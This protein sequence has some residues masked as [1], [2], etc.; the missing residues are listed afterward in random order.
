MHRLRAAPGG[1]GRARM[2]A[3]RAAR[4]RAR[5]AE[6]NATAR[7]GAGAP[8][9]VLE[10]AFDADIQRL[11]K[12]EGMWDKP[13]ARK[14]APLPAAV[15]S[16]AAAAIKAA[17]S[18]GGTAAAALGYKDLHAARC[19]WNTAHAPPGGRR[20]QAW[21]MPAG[22][23]LTAPTCGDAATAAAAAAASAAPALARPAARQCSPHLPL[24]SAAAVAAA[25]AHAPSSAPFIQPG[26]WSRR[27]RVHTTGVS[28][29]HWSLS[30]FHMGRQSSH[31]GAGTTDPGAEL[32][33]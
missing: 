10:R 18:G 19:P 4:R 32:D 23:A 22:A 8:R 7:G 26:Q 5:S 20:R 16:A 15:V 33:R 1:T 3:G 31:W 12:I 13:D 27:P 24:D 21:H 28:P 30:G 25:P 6:P 29:P 14:P 2:Q 11:L 9:Q 17:P